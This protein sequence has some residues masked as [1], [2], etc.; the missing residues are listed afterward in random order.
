M[1]KITIA[2]VGNPNSGKTSLFNALTGARQRVGNWPGVTVDRKI[3]EYDYK[4]CKVEVVDLPGVY[5]L[6]GLPGVE[7]MDETVALQYALSGEADVFVNVIDAANPERNFYLTAQ[8]IEMNVP[9]VVVLNMADRVET[10]G[11]RLDVEAIAK[12]LGCPVVSTSA[13]KLMGIEALKD[14]IMSAAKTRTPPTTTV[15]YPQIVEDKLGQLG[16]AIEPVAAA[17]KV[18]PRWLAVKLMEEDATAKGMVD[19]TVVQKLND[20]LAKIEAETG[21]DADTHIAD[22]RYTFAHGLAQICTSKGQLGASRKASDAMDR[23]VLSRWLGIPIFLVLMYLMFTFT[24]NIG[25]A[26]ID[27]FD[28][29]AGT[30]FV[31]GVG[32]LLES[33]GAPVWLKVLLA[34]GLGGGIQ[35]VATFIPIIGFLYL[36]LSVLEDSGYMARAA[37]LMDRSM[38]A[39]GLPGK[40]FVPLI[41]GFG[42]NVPSIMAARTLEQE[43]D[44]IITAMM[45]PFMSCG[46][47]LAVYALFAAAFFPVGGQNVVFAL[48]LIGIGVAILTGFILK[49]TVLMGISTPFIMELP[50][51]HV[52]QLRGV[53][54]HTWQRLKSFV[55]GAGQIIVIVVMVLS[56]LNSFGTDG[57]FGNEDSEQSILS[58]IGRAI[59][60]VFKPMGIE[61]DNWPATVGIFT[62]IFAKEAVVGTLDALYS[63]IDTAPGE[64]GAAEE[65]AGFDLVGGL[66]EAVSTIPDNLGAL[67]SLLTDPLDLGSVEV[68]SLEA[69]AEAQEVSTQTFGAMVERFDGQA[70]AFAYLLL[71]LLY[72]PCVAVMGA[73]NRELGRKWSTFAAVWTSGMAY[74]VAVGF[75]QAAT[76][77]RHPGTSLIWL[78][79][80]AAGFSLVVWVMRQ[81]GLRGITPR[82]TGAMATP[83]KSIHE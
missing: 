28:I 20:C 77:T 70:G 18:P 52:P 4:S 55:F 81:Q 76:F 14:A 22:G 1:D 75:Y 47:R 3:G 7:S 16:K 45:A 46:A 71:I 56:F 53:L 63:S 78:G 29:A 72:T 11:K 50:P 66:G 27:F 38:R 57:S 80:L 19:E 2:V 13:S 34:D 60:P 5:T 23:M 82:A 59:V 6:G 64:D 32:T 37:Y 33:I 61:D 24:I 79:V 35:V 40:A 30:I 69:A 54:I 51:Y 10:N 26:F 73:I 58:A 49:K 25:G 67:G 83:P 62:G 42:C 9:M 17:N 68:G 44:R 21:D 48:Y 41:V 36:F 39:I 15:I 31:D 43:R 65:K 8:L 12:H 74:G